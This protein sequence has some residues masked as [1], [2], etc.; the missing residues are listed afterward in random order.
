MIVERMYV[1]CSRI[2][3]GIS[4]PM[5]AGLRKIYRGGVDSG[6]NIMEG[7]CPVRENG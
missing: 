3:R 7:S 1:F 5:L 4:L 6:R 2:D